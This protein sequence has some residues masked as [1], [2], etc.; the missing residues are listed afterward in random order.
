MTRSLHRLIFVL[1]VTRNQYFCLLT[2]K[3]VNKQAD[4]VQ[5]HVEGK[6]FQKGYQYWLECQE[7]GVKFVPICKQRYVQEDQDGSDQGGQ[8]G[9]DTGRQTKH[10][11]GS[12]DVRF[13]INEHEVPKG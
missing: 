12:I 7:R 5:K 1:P 11:F 13:C 6:R 2:L 8:D 10:R 3:H 4:H 9:S